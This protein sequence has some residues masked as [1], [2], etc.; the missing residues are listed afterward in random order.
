MRSAI[1]VAVVTP[2]VRRWGH[3]QKSSFLGGCFNHHCTGSQRMRTLSQ[4]I[5]IFSFAWIANGKHISQLSLQPQI[6]ALAS[7]VHRLLWHYVRKMW[8]LICFVEYRNCISQP[9]LQP[10]LH[11]KSI[12]YKC[13]ISKTCLNKYYHS[14]RQI[15]PFFAL[16][17]HLKSDNETFISDGVWLSLRLSMSATWHLGSEEKN[18]SEF[19]FFWQGLLFQ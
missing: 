17:F 18:S 4:I 15:F 19:S 9:S 7:K 8:H 6:R 1:I 2:E 14:V 12:S 10:P 13:P 11:R 3:C 5:V 16:S